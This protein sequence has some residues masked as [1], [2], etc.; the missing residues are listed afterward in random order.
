M[1][2]TAKEPRPDCTDTAALM[3]IH[4]PATQIFW[5]SWI[6]PRH[7]GRHA[8]IFTKGTDYRATGYATLCGETVPFDEVKDFKPGA[9]F[10]E[11]CKDCWTRGVW[12]K[13]R[14]A[15]QNHSR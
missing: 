4:G 13:C 14:R 15:P 11:Q 6:T 9:D 3:D 7:A 5:V 12:I 10:T 8:Y 1:T 2:G